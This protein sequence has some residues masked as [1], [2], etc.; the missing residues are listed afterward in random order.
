MR[1][2]WGKAIKGLGKQPSFNQCIS[3]RNTSFLVFL[4]RNVNVILLQR[5]KCTQVIIPG[6]RSWIHKLML[7]QYHCVHTLQQARLWRIRV[8]EGTAA[9]A[10]DWVQ[11]AT[12]LATKICVLHRLIWVDL[13]LSFTQILGPF[14]QMPHVLVCRNSW[15]RRHST[16]TSQKSIL[17]GF[18][19][20]PHD[21]PWNT[22]I[23]DLRDVGPEVSGNG[24]QLTW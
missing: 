5:G 11:V 13:S 21:I 19:A 4:E 8:P 10:A 6:F 17:V 2:L 14:V 15:P 7:L 24:L 16:S 22:H 12:C 20:L 23:L 18:M 3:L 1:L 9:I